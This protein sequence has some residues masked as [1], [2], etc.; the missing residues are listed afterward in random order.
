MK[1]EQYLIAFLAFSV[2]MSTAAYVLVDAN[3]T[4]GTDINSTEYG[5]V[6]DTINDTYDIAVGQRDQTFGDPI[7][8][9]DTPNSLFTGSYSAIRLISGS[10]GTA[11]QIAND[12][13]TK[14]PIPSFFVSVAITTLLLMVI[15]TIILLIF[16][17]YQG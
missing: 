10:F 16:R 1:F 14:Y 5:G 9:E 7:D 8:S 11:G 17:V 6:Y 4:Y 12:I 2:V 15:G 3:N 13:A